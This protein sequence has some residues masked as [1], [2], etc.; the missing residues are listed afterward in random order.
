MPEAVERGKSAVLYCDYTLERGEE[1]YSIKLYKDQFEF[2]R[3][4]PGEQPPKQSLKLIGI[5][6]N[7]SFNVWKFLFYIA[8]IL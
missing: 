7:V 1:L 8:L 2:Y 3:Y 6:V 5:Y 4:V